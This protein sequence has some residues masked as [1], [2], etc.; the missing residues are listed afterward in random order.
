MKLTRA[1]IPVLVLL[2]F[3]GGFFVPRLWQDFQSGQQ[4]LNLP[5][6]D[7]AVPEGGVVSDSFSLQLFHAVLQGGE[8]NPMVAPLPLTDLLLHLQQ[9]SAGTTRKELENL[10]LSTGADLQSVPA[11]YGCTLAVSDDL[12]TGTVNPRLITRL[13]L[14]SSL[15]LSLSLFN[16]MIC[17]AADNP[18]GQ[19][20]DS[21]S[22][23]ADTRLLAAAAIGFTAQWQYP[24]QPG[25]TDNKADFYNADGGIPQ[26]EMM[27]LRAPLRYARAA[28]GSWEAAALFFKPQGKG[29]PLAFIAIL[30]TGNAREFGIA[31]TPAQL[32][33]IRTALVQAEPT[34]T[35]LAMPRI[36]RNTPTRDF[37]DLFR[38]MGAGAMFD[39]AK[40]DFSPITPAKLKLDALLDKET[41]HLAETGTR[42]TP[43][44][45]V[46]QGLQKLTLDKP[47]IWLVADLTSPMPPHF[48]G[49][50]ENR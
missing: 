40:A 33:E 34:D 50:E 48:M 44:G 3:A 36:S 4:E 32:S 49:L 2:G 23:N 43:D 18:D 9:A 8:Q 29:T 14:K 46:S 42:H 37:A 13:P 7:I 25:D 6:R 15:P 5:L 1:T 16:G 38:R 21:T 45:T 30:P 17:Q 27:H 47:F 10:R 39:P 28:D 19:M 24:F 26:V 31:L 35:T 41:I 12:P 22:L 20:V 11:H